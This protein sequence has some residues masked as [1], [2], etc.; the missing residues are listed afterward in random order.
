[1]SGRIIGLFTGQTNA[2]I[3]R[4]DKANQ[5][6]WALGQDAY[7]DE[8]AQYGAWQFDPWP[9]RSGMTSVGDPTLDTPINNRVVFFEDVRYSGSYNW[10]Y[11]IKGLCLDNGGNPVAGATVELYNALTEYQVGVMSSY[12]DG[13]YAF[14]VSDNTTPYY[15]IAWRSA[16]ALG[17]ISTRTLVGA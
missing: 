5:P 6:F 11:Y 10:P 8:D 4:S 7:V 9:A 15:V 12:S 16:P 3:Q 17:G 2:P 13:T 1:M 14:G